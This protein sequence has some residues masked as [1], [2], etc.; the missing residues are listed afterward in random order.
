MTQASPPLP[1]VSV[2]IPT[3][4]GEARIG[5]AIRSL[6]AQQYPNMEIIISDNDSSDDTEGV[7]QRFMKEDDRIRYFRHPENMGIPKNFEFGLQKAVGKYFIWLSDDDQLISGIIK[8]YVDF[9]ESEPSFS[10]ISGIINYT[11]EG[12]VVAQEKNIDLQQSSGLSRCLEYYMRVRE[13]G[14]YYGMMRREFGQQLGVGPMMGGDWHFVAG[15][16]YLGKI[17]I[18][19]FVGYSKSRGGVSSDFRD[20]ARTY[21]EGAIWGYLPFVKIG[22]DAASEIIFRAGVFRRTNWLKRSLAGIGAC[23]LVW[24]HYYGYILPRMGMGW[25]LR[26]LNIKTL[27][28]RSL[29]KVKI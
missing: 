12:R 29:E 1:L 14:M 23:I 8:R 28:Q 18:L 13:G 27:R 5:E 22:L 16:A 10:M 21:G 9:L 3:Y 17:K 20:Y 2:S 7:V 26:K 19:D 15:L 24:G 4:N 11:E 25:V 6:Q